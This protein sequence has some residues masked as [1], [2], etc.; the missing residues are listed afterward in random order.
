MLRRLL[1]AVLALVA[2][3]GCQAGVSTGSVAEPAGAVPAAQ[4]GVEDDAV[5]VLREWDEAR[6]AAYAV[7]SL[8]ALRR[9]YVEG[10]AAGRADVR[11]LRAYVDRGLVVRGMRMQVLSVE[12]VSRTATTLRLRVTDRLV[13]AVAVA[14]ETTYPLPADSADDRVLDLRLV[15]G[16]WRVAG[17]RPARP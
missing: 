13:G 16:G 2:L 11:M 9:L 7:G 3:T 17:V 14:G 4:P 10:S 5:L 15:A 6:A 1:A 8:P 12:V